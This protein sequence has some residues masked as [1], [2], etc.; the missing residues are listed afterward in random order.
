MRDI[1]Q[2][3]N[4]IMDVIDGTYKHPLPRCKPDIGPDMR[5]VT[6]WKNCFDYINHYGYGYGTDYLFANEYYR[7]TL[8]ASE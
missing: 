8:E 1:I 4:N 2:E 7:M 6:V 3:I 5:H